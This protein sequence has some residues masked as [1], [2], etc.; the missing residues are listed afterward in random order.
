MLKLAPERIYATTDILELPAARER[1]ERMT[2][3]TDHLLDLGHA[4]LTI[5]QWS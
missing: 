1:T 2:A 3:N 5:L 4:G